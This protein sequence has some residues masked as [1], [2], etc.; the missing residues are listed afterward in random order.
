MDRR[1][2]PPWLAEGE[3]RTGPTTTRVARAGAVSDHAGS[4]AKRRSESPAEDARGHSVLVIVYHLLSR[5]ELYHDL[6][7]SYFDEGR[8]ER[9]ERGL[10]RRLQD[11]GHKVSLEPAQPN[12]SAA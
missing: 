5:G 10:V 2:A 6:G 1:S 7:V 8:R 3:L 4:R 9:L 12:T 11:L